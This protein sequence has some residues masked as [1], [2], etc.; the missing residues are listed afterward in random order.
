MK[1]SIKL[2]ALLF[3]IPSFLFSQS[4]PY[5]LKIVS[6]L[7][8]YKKLVQENPN[9]LLIDIKHYIPEIVLDIRYATTDNFT[10]EQIYT[11]AKA[12]LRRPV[13]DSLKKVQM[14]LSKIGLGLKVFDAYRPYAATLKFYEVFPDTTYVAA[15]W[16]GSRHNYGCAVDLTLIELKTGREL[17]MPT[18]FDDF[19][20]K[21][22]HDYND[23]P[24]DVIENRELLKKV[25][26]KYGFKIYP[27]EWWHYDFYD[28]QNYEILD[29]PFEKLVNN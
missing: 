18:E 11:L 5:N 15:P 27:D 17:R 22:H 24:K 8:E 13:A 16:K 14:E 26:E 28:W 3:I 6:D 10:K 29:I 19:T 9:K 20:S 21:A 1:I 4:N 12:F 2:F 7:E 23:L 25:M